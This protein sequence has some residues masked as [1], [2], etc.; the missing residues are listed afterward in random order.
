MV[1]TAAACPEPWSWTGNRDHALNI[2]YLLYKPKIEEELELFDILVGTDS[3]DGFLKLLIEN[4][5]ATRPELFGRSNIEGAEAAS[6][7]FGLNLRKDRFDLSEFENSIK[8]VRRSPCLTGHTTSKAYLK[9]EGCLAMGGRYR[10]EI[11]VERSKIYLE[12]IK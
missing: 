8:E 12:S 1:L 11:S 5:D 6:G 4:D 9:L 3:N 10:L 7:Y 2:D